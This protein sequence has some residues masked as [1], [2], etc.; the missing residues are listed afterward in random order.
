MPNHYY[1]SYDN[2]Q[3]D[4]YSQQGYQQTG[5]QGYQQPGYQQY[6]QPGYQQYQY[7]FQQPGSFQP[8]MQGGYKPDSNLV[9]AILTTIFCCLPFGIVSIVYAAKVDSLW[10]QGNYQGAQDA[11]NK[12]KTWAMWAAIS[13]IIVWVL[14][15]IAVFVA[16]VSL[17]EFGRY[18]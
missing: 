1:N 18:Y 5:Y 8:G 2:Q 7:A 6:Q 15:I 13:S 10:A 9:W 12:A 11:S 16:G 14:Y 4:P 17:L 3:Q